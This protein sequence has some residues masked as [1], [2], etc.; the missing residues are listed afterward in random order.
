MLTLI[1][2]SEEGLRDSDRQQIEV[3]HDRPSFGKSGLG[4]GSLILLLGLAT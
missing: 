3:G 4:H 2:Q 1:A